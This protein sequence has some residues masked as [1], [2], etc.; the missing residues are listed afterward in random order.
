MCFEDE[1]VE[2]LGADP[3][4][5]RFNAIAMKMLNGHYYPKDAVQVFG[6]FQEEQRLIQSGDRLLQRAPL[7]PFYDGLVAWSMVEI[8]VAERSETTCSIGYVTTQQHHARGIWRADLV[9]E[10][11]SLK[12]TVKSTACPRSFLFWLGLPFARFL[13]LRARRRAVE[14][15]R[16]I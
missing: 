15:F 6:L 4:G 1:L 14:E 8:F 7:L 2:E 10:N 9:L 11:G 16:H 12:L 3:N 5:A 13:Q